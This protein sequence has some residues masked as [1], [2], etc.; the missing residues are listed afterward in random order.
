MIFLFIIPFFFYNKNNFNSIIYLKI[1]F[2][3]RFI[4]LK[5][6]FKFKF[7]FKTLLIG[8]LK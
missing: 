6:T 4:Y 2:L 8:I 1:L 5:I 7:S 3:I